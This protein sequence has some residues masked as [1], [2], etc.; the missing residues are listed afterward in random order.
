MNANK[1]ACFG[2]AASQS[3]LSNVSDPGSHSYKQRLAQLAWECYQ[4]FISYMAFTNNF[5]FDYQQI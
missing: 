4:L 2:S 3:V 5:L 1:Y